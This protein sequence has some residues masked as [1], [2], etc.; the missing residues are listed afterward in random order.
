ML[1]SKR[2]G[3]GQHLGIQ[4]LDVVGSETRKKMEIQPTT[5]ELHHATS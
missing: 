3:F 1:F 5:A 2:N 4:F